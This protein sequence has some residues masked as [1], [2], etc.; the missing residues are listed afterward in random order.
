MN[1]MSCG[2]SELKK[3]WYYLSRLGTLFYFYSQ[4]VNAEKKLAFKE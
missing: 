2:M 4:E 1:N 3:Y